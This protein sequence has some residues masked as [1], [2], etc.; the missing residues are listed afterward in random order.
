MLECALSGQSEVENF[1]VVMEKAHEPDAFWAAKCLPNCESSSVM[2]NILVVCVCVCMLR[3]VVV[4]EGFLMRGGI[5]R[6]CR[7][8]TCARLSDYITV[9]AAMTLM[10]ITVEKLHAKGSGGGCGCVCIV[11]FRVMGMSF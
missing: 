6:C 7:G 1:L 5:S 8:E 11:K 2:I 9:G 3:V 4:L 10:G